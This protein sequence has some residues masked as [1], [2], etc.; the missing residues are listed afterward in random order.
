[1]LAGGE[2]FCRA[3]FGFVDL[4]AVRLQASDGAFDLDLGVS[5]TAAVTPDHDG[6][7]SG[8]GIALTD[9]GLVVAG[10][11]NGSPALVRF[12]T[13]P[14]GGGG[15]GGGAA[16]AV[17]A[18]GSTGR[19]GAALKKCKHKHHRARAKCKKKANR[20]PA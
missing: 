9:A 7:A 6:H 2:V 20:L 8:S 4:G 12:F 3:P 16:G 18:S 19:R 15:G 17:G 10:R 1:V 13:A 5:G 14:E 11:V